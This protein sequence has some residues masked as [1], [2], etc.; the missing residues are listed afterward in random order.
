MMI[1]LLL[2]MVV[3][4]TNVLLKITNPSKEIQY[5]LEEHDEADDDGNVNN[6]GFDFVVVPGGD[7]GGRGQLF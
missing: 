2:V 6:D 3:V 7:G 5:E 4:A 1:M